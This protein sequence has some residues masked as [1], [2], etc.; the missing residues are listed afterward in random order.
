MYRR[1][2]I[3]V[4]FGLS[5][6]GTISSQELFPTSEPASTI[7][8]GVI[9]TRLTTES[10]K[11]VSIFRNL[12]S[13]RLMYGLFSNLTVMAN[14]TESNHHGVDFPSGLATHTH[15]GNK[16]VFSSGNFQRGLI[17]PYLFT[18]IDLYAKF[19]FFNRDGEHSHL[20]MALYGEWSNVSVAHD[21]AEPTL[22]DDTK[23][24]GGGLIITVLKNHLA[25]SLTSGVIIPGSYDGMSPDPL[26]GPDVPTTLTYGKAVKY[27][28]SIGYLLFPAKY[29]NYNEPNINVYLEFKGKSYEEASIIQYG[30]KPVPIQTPLLE[31]GNYVDVFPGIQT[32]LHS[33]MRIDFCVGFP[34][35]NQS[36]A[37]F[38][39]VYMFGI[40]RY[41]YLHKK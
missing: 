16:S 37:H 31:A 27:D 13:A 22:L 39:P 6:Q 20:R 9:G 3:I 18:G 26:G 35:I 15:N 14:F 38:Y 17:Y 23:G 21:E 34:L 32:I 10:Y 12:A 8:K 40:Q 4:A 30:I 19:R 36:Y 24:Y 41:F 33:N 7:P 25:I 11:E 2:I 28:L 29:H 1:L 5:F